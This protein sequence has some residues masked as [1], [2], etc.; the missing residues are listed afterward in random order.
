MFCSD[1]I[2]LDAIMSIF[3]GLHDKHGK[4]KYPSGWEKLFKDNW[5]LLEKIDEVIKNYNE[6]NA[7]DSFY[8]KPKEV[9]KI[10]KLLRP[11]QI[12]VIILGQDPY[13]S[14]NEDEEPVAMGL[15]FSIRK[16]SP[17]A[18]SLRNIFKVIER[19]TGKKSTCCK[20]G[21]LTPWAEQGVFLL[22]ACL[23]V[24][25]GKAGSHGNIWKGFVLRTLDFIFKQTYEVPLNETDLT[26]DEEDNDSGD[27]DNES[28]INVEINSYPIALLWGRFAQEYERNCKGLV[29]KTSHPSPFSFTK[30]FSECDHF[31]LVNKILKSQKKTII[32]W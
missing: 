8:P 28:K 22:N 29:L 32:K 11:E 7:V 2:S 24:A 14:M 20:T 19:D 16:G 9:F 3:E 17:I 27:E 25:P 6:E 23:T 13:H 30:G 4:R 15:A 5:H 31:S 1:T 18:P 10:Y 26:D 12:K 21:D